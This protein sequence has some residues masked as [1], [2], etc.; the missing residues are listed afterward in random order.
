MNF[1]MS[2]ADMMELLRHDM[3]RDFRC[4]AL[5][6]QVG[7]VKLTQSGGHDLRGG[8]GGGYI[9]EVTVPAKDALLERP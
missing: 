4:V 8:F 3:L 7:E 9:R 1:D 5:P 2:G 6:A